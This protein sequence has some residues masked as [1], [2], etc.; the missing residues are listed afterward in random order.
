M[1]KARII[2]FAKRY[3]VA[4]LLTSAFIARLVFL[5][6]RPLDGDEGVVIKIANS[7]GLPDLW[8]NIAKDVHPP[9]FHLLQFSF[10][11]IFPDGEF[12]LRLLPA[13]LGGVT[14]YF[15]YLFFRSQVNERTATVVA[16]L[17]IFSPVLSYHSA[18]VRPYPLLAL[19]FF[20]SLH[21]LMKSIQTNKASD[22]TWYGI[23]SLLLLLTQ[24]IGFII[25]FAQLAYL[26]IYKRKHLGR[27]IVASILSLLAFFAIWGGQ[28]IDQVTGRLSEQ[29]QALSISGNLTGLVNFFYRLGSGRLFLDLDPSPANQISFLQS[30]PILY[31]L[32]LL[33][34]IIP[35]VL[36]IIGIVKYTRGRKSVRVLNVVCI[37]LLITAVFSSEI[38]PKTV[39]YYLFLSP[40]YI[41]ILVSALQSSGR[42]VKVLFGIFLPIYL[43]AFVYGVYFERAKPGVDAFAQYISQGANEGDKILVKG[44]F[45]G[46][47]SYV[48]RYYLINPSKYEIVDFFESYKAG[49]LSE[50]R[51]KA[52]VD[53]IKDNQGGQTVYFYNMT[54]EDLD[55]SIFQRV[56]MIDLGTDK[57]GKELTLYRF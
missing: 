43:S 12:Y 52:T 3:R 39:R 6:L 8:T 22:W 5:G 17:S 55:L 50:L 28:F 40:V 56:E 10:Q 48:L 38:G 4:V 7:A 30:A 14:I 46:G 24:Y 29:S 20:V 25:I 23:V 49:N 13:I 31:V 36:F 2:N 1:Q 35:L 37:I 51:D 26:V 11:R 45:G 16:T 47:E 53:F 15:I 42:T 9:L 27:F 21:L 19:L 41:F 34:V 57:E 32:F 18:E 44:G 54:Y 33:S